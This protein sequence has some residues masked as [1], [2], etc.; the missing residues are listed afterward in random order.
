MYVWKKLDNQTVLVS[1]LNLTE[2]LQ[3]VKWNLDRVEVG[4]TPTINNDGSI[5]LD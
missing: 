4:Q 1:S 3:V 2:Q 5:L